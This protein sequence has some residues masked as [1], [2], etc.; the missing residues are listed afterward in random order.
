V[1]KQ[2]RKKIIETP[3]GLRH[4]KHGMGQLN[5]NSYGSMKNQSFYM[6]EQL[7]EGRSPAGCD[8]LPMI[9]VLEA[10]EK[11]DRR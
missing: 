8:T 7:I 1:P 6:Q 11:G 2:K 5:G 3:A 9:D 4:R 10:Q